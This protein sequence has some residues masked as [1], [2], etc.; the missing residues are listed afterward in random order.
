MRHRDKE[1]PMEET[2]REPNSKGKFMRTAP[3]K[4]QGGRSEKRKGSHAEGLAG[5]PEGRRTPTQQSRVSVTEGRGNRRAQP[6]AHVQPFGTALSH[7]MTYTNSDSKFAR[8][9]AQRGTLAA[10]TCA[11][12]CHLPRVS[13]LDTGTLPSCFPSHHITMQHL[14]TVKR[15][16]IFA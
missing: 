11:S 14:L 7:L 4:E 13:S 1:E 12:N 15:V 8:V 10:L 16:K 5:G 9:R 3:A 6:S 2:E